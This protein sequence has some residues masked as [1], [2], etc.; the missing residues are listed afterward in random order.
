MKIKVKESMKTIPF[1]YLSKEKVKKSKSKIKDL[2]YNELKIQN[3]F[4]S[5]KIPSKTK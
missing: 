3:Y 5:D 2:K 1:A 4:K